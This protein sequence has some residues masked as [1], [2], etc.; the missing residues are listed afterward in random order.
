MEKIEH[1]YIL[2]STVSGV[3]D[4]NLKRLEK[5]LGITLSIRGDSLLI[6]GPQEKVEFSKN[7]FSKLR[8][9][10]EKGRVD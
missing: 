4:K 10:E 1:P 5:R 8:E 6:D 3:L 9:L 7:Y 2:K